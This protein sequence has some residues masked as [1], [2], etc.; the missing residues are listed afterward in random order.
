MSQHFSIDVSPNDEGWFEARCDCGWNGGM[1]PDAEDLCDALMQ[2][3]YEQGWIDA[4][5][6]DNPP[7]RRPA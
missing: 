2:H 4:K 6:E 5:H 1:F 7:E 3:A